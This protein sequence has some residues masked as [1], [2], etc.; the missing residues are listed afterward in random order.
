MTSSDVA[1]NERSNEEKRK[2]CK[3]RLET[4]RMENG[5]LQPVSAQE[6]RPRISTGLR[7]ECQILVTDLE[8]EK[9]SE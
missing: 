2:E 7:F 9:R 3:N 4:K 1:L 8:G 5:N 6:D